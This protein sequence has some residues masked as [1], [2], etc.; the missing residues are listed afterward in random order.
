MEK[1]ILELNDPTVYS[2]YD[3]Q[4]ATKQTCAQVPVVMKQKFNFWSTYYLNVSYPHLPLETLAF[5]SHL[6]Q[7][8]VGGL[9]L[10]RHRTHKFTK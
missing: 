6:H 9:T 4:E 10:Q 5:K 7:Q 2:A 3:S 8:R 1:L